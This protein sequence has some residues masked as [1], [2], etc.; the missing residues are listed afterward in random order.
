MHG[1][2]SV[3]AQP[4]GPRGECKCRHKCAAWTSHQ[5]QAVWTVCSI[6]CWPQQ[7]MLGQKLAVRGIA[8]WLQALQ[9]CAMTSIIEQFMKLFKA[10][11][12]VYL[13]GWCLGQ[14]TWE[15]LL[16]LL[17][18][19]PQVPMVTSCSCPPGPFLGRP[20]FLAGPACTI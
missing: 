15:A 17:G 12:H 8:V 18:K 5:L 7:S 19:R 9:A 1:R 13:T 20:S 11:Q 3:R 14:P 2:H 16:Q 10:G 6:H 4:L